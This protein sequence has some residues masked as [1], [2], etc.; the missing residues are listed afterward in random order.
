MS[1]GCPLYAS[2]HILIII[3][4]VF[5]YTCCNLWITWLSVT[6]PDL[7][8]GITERV[9]R[10]IRHGRAWV[11]TGCRLF[12]LLIMWVEHY[13]ITSLLLYSSALKKVCCQ[14]Q[15]GEPRYW[16]LQSIWSLFQMSLSCRW[17]RSWVIMRGHMDLDRFGVT[18]WCLGL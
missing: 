17:Y 16:L 14:F 6:V 11:R 4:V 9:I 8:L 12:R 15:L 18:I 2:Y 7:F 1:K 5:S 10:D 3:L 13:S